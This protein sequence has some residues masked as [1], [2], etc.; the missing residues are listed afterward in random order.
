MQVAHKMDWRGKIA[1]DHS[2]IMMLRG[3]CA[4]YRKHLN[5]GVSINWRRVGD[6][7]MPSGLSSLRRGKGAAVGAVS[8]TPMIR[9]T[10]AGRQYRVISGVAKV[11]P[12]EPSAVRARAGLAFEPRCV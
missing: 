6:S 1:R 7:P 12:H 2:S 5:A 3:M 10:S 8:A 9:S 4:A 11:I